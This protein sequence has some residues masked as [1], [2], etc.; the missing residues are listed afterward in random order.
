[1]LRSG[2]RPTR[3]Q[4]HVPTTHSVAALARY[5]TKKCR[6]HLCQMGTSMTFLPSRHIGHSIWPTTLESQDVSRDGLPH[7]HATEMHLVR[8]LPVRDSLKLFFNRKT[9]LTN[10]DCL[11]LIRF[12]YPVTSIPALVSLSLDSC[13]LCSM[14]RLSSFFICFSFIV[15]RFSSPAPC[16]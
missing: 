8:F 1:M 10:C 5:A 2:P 12:G 16:L 11:F 15:F 4:R 6:P 14:S 13:R 9:I 3:Q 7:R